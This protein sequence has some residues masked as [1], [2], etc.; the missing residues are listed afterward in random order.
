MAFYTYLGMLFYPVVK[1][2]V[3]GNYY[4]E[5]SASMDRIGAIFARDPAIQEIPRPLRLNPLR[6]SIRFEGVSFQYDEA[7]GD[8]LTGINLDIK[9]SE[10]VALVGKSGAGKTTL[11]NLL[12]RFY[13]PAKGA[14]YIDGHNLKDLALDAYRSQIAVVLQDD[15]LFRASIKDNICYG[16]PDASEEEIIR[17][18]ALSR[19]HEFIADLPRGYDTDIG[20]RGVMLS[21]GQ[22]QRISIARALLRDPALLIL[23]EATSNIDSETERAIIEHAFGNLIAG[24][25]TI[26]IAHRHSALMRAN[27]IICLDNGRIVDNS[28]VSE[29][30]STIRR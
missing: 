11:M 18:A 13:D 22:R 21:N 19:A 7:G 2:V 5:A 14:V 1:L 15:C 6:G 24:R 10:V 27:R 12:L 29:L 4:Q 25:T 9:Q 16:K 20:E 30:A 8:V 3:V 17:A 23:D 28:Y 26:V